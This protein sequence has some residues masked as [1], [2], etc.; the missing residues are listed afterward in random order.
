MKYL[1]TLRDRDVIQSV[2]VSL[3]LAVH[4][5]MNAF[6]LL[7]P[8]FFATLHVS[9]SGVFFPDEEVSPKTDEVNQP[10]PL[11]V[12]A[13]EKTTTTTA[14]P[15]IVTTEKTTTNAPPKTTEKT[16]TNADEGGKKPPVVTID[17]P[18]C[19]CPETNCTCEES[20]NN[21]IDSRNIIGTCQGS[22]R[23]CY[24]PLEVGP[25]P[26]G[27]RLELTEVQQNNTENNTTE[28][29]VLLKCKIPSCP[30]A[31]FVQWGNGTCVEKVSKELCPEGWYPAENSYGVAECECDLNRVY[32]PGD[33][34][35]HEL[36]KQ[37]PCEKGKALVVNGITNTIECQET[38]C[39]DGEAIWPQDQQCYTLLTPGP[40]DGGTFELDEDT[41][42][43]KCGNATTEYQVITAKDKPCRAG[44]FRDHLVSSPPPFSSFP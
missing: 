37:G 22:N 43:P 18:S 33:K 25:C 44:S 14:P 11:K 2:L 23:H 16:T 8:F 31:D 10:T 1:L 28:T 36:Y 3:S 20:P 39:K 19:P 38:I 7:L 26:E 12:V 30:E 32:W 6:L 42:Q 9:H 13:K 24:E 17:I 35:C 40:C 21:S 4:A 41:F 34:Q 5:K 29:V 15:K 27:Y